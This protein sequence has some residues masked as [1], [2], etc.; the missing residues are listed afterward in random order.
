[1][2]RGFVRFVLTRIASAA[3]LVLVVASA[4]LVLVELAPGGEI[5]GARAAALAERQ[6]LGLDRPL[7]EQYS[8][9]LA[10]AARLDLGRSVRFGVPVTSLIRERAGNTLLLGLTALVLATLLGVPL[11]VFTGT[12]RTG[13]TKVVRLATVILLSV[14]PIVTSL[15]L[16]FAAYRTGWL[17]AGGL[18]PV[19]PDTGAIDAILITVRYLALP[20]LALALPIAATLERLQSRA[21][22]EALGDPCILA[23]RARGISSSRL[24]WRHAWPLSLK[25]VLA[26][27]GVIVGSVL[28]GSF[29]VEIVMS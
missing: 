8:A 16:L 2:P 27:Y 22:R 25:P 17:P 12:R 20:S 24:I 15:L 4:A 18:P 23:A 5:G 9:W 3:L 6:R 28:S 13:P 26:V 11:G 1:V 10:R 7:V 19:G 29:A 14:P 21:I